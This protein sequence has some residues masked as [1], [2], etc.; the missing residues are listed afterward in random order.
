MPGILS[1]NP[2][3]SNTQKLRPAL[4]KPADNEQ[5]TP[6]PAVA[7]GVSKETRAY[8][9]NRQRAKK[10]AETAN[11]RVRKLAKATGHLPVSHRQ[12]RTPA[13]AVR[14]GSRSSEDVAN[15]DDTPVIDA[16]HIEEQPQEVVSERLD[17]SLAD[18]VMFRKGRKG[19]G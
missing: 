11:L 17:V 7:L 4:S 9:H 10:T 1:V 15:V 2:L 16:G 19:I 5:G 13:K 3:S 6:L 18:F 14:K 8:E 12:P